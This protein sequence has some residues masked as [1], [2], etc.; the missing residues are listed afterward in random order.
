MQLR[1]ILALVAG[2]VTLSSFADARGI[3]PGQYSLFGGLQQVCLNS[4]G[5]WYG[6]TFNFGG[7]WKKDLPSTRDK[8]E[9]HGGYAMQGHGYQG[10]GNTAIMVRKAEAGQ[11]YI[12]WHDWFDDLSYETVLVGGRIDLVKL[13]CDP[14]FTGENTHAATQGN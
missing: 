13:T 4:D 8:A 6:T 9:L 7:H 1:A 2:A 3:G 10:Y 5:T 12:T 14:P 11:L